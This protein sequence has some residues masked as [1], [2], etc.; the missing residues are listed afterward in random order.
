MKGK[1]IVLHIGPPKAATTTIQVFLDGARDDLLA[2]G[3]LYPRAARLQDGGQY[4]VRRPEGWR[5]FGG[6]MASHQFLA[7]TLEGVVEGLSP[8]TCWG[9]LLGEIRDAPAGKIVLSAEAF[10]HLPSRDILRVRKYLDRC[11][12][13]VVLYLRDPVGR[14]LSASGPSSSNVVTGRPVLGS[15]PLNPSKNKN[16]PTL[17]P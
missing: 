8:E 5:R 12:V 14:T 16:C 17:T 10:A 6:P 2:R 9:A 13:L 11:D 3:V 1:H 7:W 15:T 4:R